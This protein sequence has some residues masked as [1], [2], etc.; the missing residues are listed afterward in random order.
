MNNMMNFM[1]MIG[2]PQQFLSSL[3]SNTA[4]MQNPI[5]KNAIELYQ[6]GD[7]KGLENL[8]SNVAK[9]RGTSIDEIRKQ[10]GI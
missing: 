8:V 2:N 6:R 4:C 1:Q 5:M 3:V 7:N 9:E 10:M